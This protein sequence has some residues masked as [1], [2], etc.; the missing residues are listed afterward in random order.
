MPLIHKLRDA[1]FKT[2]IERN[3][4]R[5]ENISTHLP[6]FHSTMVECSMKYRKTR[7]RLSSTVDSIVGAAHGMRKI[8]QLVRRDVS[9]VLM[10]RIL[11]FLDA[12][13]CS[14]VDRYRHFERKYSLHPQGLRSPRT[15]RCF[16]YGKI[17]LSILCVSGWVDPRA[18]LG[19]LKKRTICCK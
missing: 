15:Y 14:R 3:T 2:L 10:P 18:G 7:R 12:M 19:V 9:I 17:F 1:D 13:W 4:C 5:T 11:V 8:R 16:T 6:L